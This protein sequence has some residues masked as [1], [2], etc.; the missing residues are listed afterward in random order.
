MGR[1][2]RRERRLAAEYEKRL[3]NV[4]VY[5]G[6]G[7]GLVVPDE[8]VRVLGRTKVHMVL[9]DY[10]IDFATAVDAVELSR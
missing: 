10:G 4:A 6:P 9:K 2:N 7:R 5:A 1:L 8:W 3:R